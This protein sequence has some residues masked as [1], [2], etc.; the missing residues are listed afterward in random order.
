M[1]IYCPAANNR[2]HECNRSTFLM[3]KCGDSGRRILFG[4]VPL[5]GCPWGEKYIRAKTTTGELKIETPNSST[6][7]ITRGHTVYKF[8]NGKFTQSRK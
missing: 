4:I 5:G 3:G 7:Q 6:L 8:V 1:G 2:N